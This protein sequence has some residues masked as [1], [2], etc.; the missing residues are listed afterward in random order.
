MFE[1]VGVMYDAGRSRKFL[2]IIISKYE[3]LTDSLLI[4]SRRLFSPGH[5]FVTHLE[6]NVYSPLSSAQTHV[7]IFFLHGE[8][9]KGKR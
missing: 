9:P 7:V 8:K 4:F 5:V 2:S 1:V 6:L 3:E